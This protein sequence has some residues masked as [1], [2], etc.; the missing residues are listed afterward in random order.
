MCFILE[1]DKV[2]PSK[3]E[4]FDDPE[5]DWEKLFSAWHIVNPYQYIYREKKSPFQ[6]IVVLLAKL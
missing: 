2:F 6:N 1:R 5:G 4:T 3:F